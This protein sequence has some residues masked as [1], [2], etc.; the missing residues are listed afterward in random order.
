[1]SDIAI[2][3]Y[4][5]LSFSNFKPKSFEGSK[6]YVHKFIYTDIISIQFIGLSVNNYSL[7]IR[8]YNGILYSTDNFSKVTIDT[9][10]SYF[11]VSK[12][13]NASNFYIANIIKDG[14]IVST[15]QWFTVQEEAED[16][17]LFE[18]THS[19]NEYDTIFLDN[20]T[21]KK[22]QFRMDGGF[23]SDGDKYLSE[24]EF[25]RNQRQ[26]IEKQYDMPYMKHTLIIGDNM[27][28]PSWVAEKINLIMALDN[29]TIDGVLFVRSEDS[30]PEQNKIA[31]FYP[32]FNYTFILETKENVFYEKKK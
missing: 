20:G 27:G 3:K 9:N 15:S 23:S 14:V 7:E 5:S 18:Y 22:F 1:M 28:V 19:K 25:R 29:V 10:N 31:E 30:I 17:V 16:T 24:V 8:D 21:Q 11:S 13:I 6:I 4:S 32:Y 12:T 26:E 2:S